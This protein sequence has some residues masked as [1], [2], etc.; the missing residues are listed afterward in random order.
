[1]CFKFRTVEASA[2]P[3]LEYATAST[4]VNR[5]KEKAAYLDEKTTRIDKH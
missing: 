2:A 4:P 5:T 3:V 1:M